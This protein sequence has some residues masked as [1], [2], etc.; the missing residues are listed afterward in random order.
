MEDLDK[1]I[2]AGSQ[3]TDWFGS[4]FDNLQA[5]LKQTAFKAIAPPGADL[6]LKA[7][8]KGVQHAVG[9]V[10]TDLVDPYGYG[11]KS[12]KPS[13]VEEVMDILKYSKEDPEYYDEVASRATKRNKAR[14]FPFR[15]GFGL[16]SRD[17]W[18]KIYKQNE[19]GTYRF[20]TVDELTKM[21]ESG[22]LSKKQV[23]VA[24][25][26]ITDMKWAEDG[27]H[28]QLMAN[29][30]SS[31]N[32]DGSFN[33]Y[34]KWDFAINEGEE[35]AWSKFKKWNDDRDN[36]KNKKN[37]LAHLSRVGISQLFDPVEFKGTITEDDIYHANQLSEE[38]RSQY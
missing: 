28:D 3:E 23:L 37:L 21:H 7:A 36:M 22:E 35:S 17:N 12:Y 6:A 13:K 5:V 31:R 38:I 27:S 34:D 29:Y 14:E 20:S 4:L 26:N 1:D 8:R 33:Y 30:E 24:L 11:T 9:G 25:K 18:E 32:E 2:E 10:V 15:Q 19:D 16:P